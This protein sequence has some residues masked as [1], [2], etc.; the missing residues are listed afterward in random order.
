MTDPQSF[1]QSQIQL[2]VSHYSSTSN[3]TSNSSTYLTR[4]CVNFLISVTN[5]WDEILYNELGPHSST[6]K[7]LYTDILKELQ[8]SLSSERA[9]TRN[10]TRYDYARV[11]MHFCTSREFSVFEKVCFFE[12]LNFC[13]LSIPVGLPILQLYFQSKG[14]YRFTS[15]HFQSISIIFTHSGGFSATTG[16]STRITCTATL[17][18]NERS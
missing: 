15:L 8:L 18:E 10:F 9:E 11:V 7:T 4:F 13:H 3:S 2:L 14:I 12:C 5:G 6:Y 16:R 17:S 1:L